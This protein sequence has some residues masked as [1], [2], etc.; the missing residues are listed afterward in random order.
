MIYKKMFQKINNKIKN[1]SVQQWDLQLT[2]V[3]L[4]H[5]TFNSAR[6]I[7]KNN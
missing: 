7:I 4:C 6:K 3:V 5:I 2:S 1:K